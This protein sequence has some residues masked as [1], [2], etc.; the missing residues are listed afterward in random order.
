VFSLYFYQGRELK[1]A[2]V[3]LQ[4]QVTVGRDP[5]NTVSLLDSSVSR[6]HATFFLQKVG[7][8]TRILLRDEGSTN[9]CEV[10]GQKVK[11]KTVQVGL[12]DFIKIGRFR[13][14]LQEQ[15]SLELPKEIED[16]EQTIIYQGPPLCRESLPI[17]RLKALYHFTI[18]VSH[19]DMEQMCELAA[20]VVAGCLHYDV[21]CVFLNDE[22]GSPTIRAWNS[23]GRCSPSDVSMSRSVLT[24]CLTQN[25]AILA[26]KKE[27]D[28]LRGTDTIAWK[29]LSSAICVPLVGGLSNLGAIYVAS[30]A[31]AVVYSG[32]ELQFLILVANHVASNMVSR[33]ALQEFRAEAEKLEAVLATLQEG[34]LVTDQ[35]FCILSAN[36]AAKEIFSAKDLTGKRLEDALQGFRHTFQPTLLPTRSS[37]EVETIAR[38]G[39]KRIP[40]LTF[41]ATVSENRGPEQE[42]WKYVICL[43]DISQVERNERMKSVFVSRLAHKLRTPLTLISQ[44]NSL[45]AQHAG[46][47]LDPELRNMVGQSLEH[48]AECGA[49]IERFVEYTSLNRLQDPCG[50]LNGRCSVE[51]LV[52]FAL[53]LNQDLILKKS[54]YIGRQFPKEPS[55]VRGDETRLRLVFH[56]IVQNAAKFGKQSGMLKITAVEGNQVVTIQFLDDGPGIP[57]AEMEYL[58]QLLHQVDLEDTANVPGAGLGLWLAREIVQAHQGQIKVISPASEKGQGTLVEI[59]LPAATDAKLERPHGKLVDDTTLIKAGSAP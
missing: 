39:E 14:Q 33:K 49:L 6:R 43:H 24:K 20:K 28:P 54:L 51:S 3:P 41:A 48:S 56:H 40:K 25:L 8:E 13:V 15:R 38:V 50:S 44:V 45:V 30:E 34:V 23:R 35:R 18:E 22:L 5:G 7:K 10:N 57:P 55:V 53:Q 4:R 21:F 37:F 42:S 46:E 59:L 31:P 19:L 12:E 52:D 58:F 9:G 1:V 26:D 16:S 17:D 2:G 47:F 11:D 32:E 29:S 27:D 36:K